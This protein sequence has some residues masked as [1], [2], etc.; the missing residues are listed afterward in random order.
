MY[1]GPWQ[2][3]ALGRALTQQQTR[4][5]GRLP[6]LREEA[7]GAPSDAELSQFVSA[8]KDAAAQLDEA[9][10]KNLLLWSPLFMP[11][12]QT[13][14]QPHGAAPPAAAAA[15]PA[16]AG[17]GR[18]RGGTAG[19][20]AP[21]SDGPRGASSKPPRRKDPAQTKR[22]NVQRQRDDRMDQ[23]RKLY[24]Y[25]DP[26]SCE[27]TL[28][29]DD[30]GEANG[31]QQGFVRATAMPASVR[32]IDCGGDPTATAAALPLSPARRTGSPPS[33]G[34]TPLRR[35]SPARCGAAHLVSLSDEWEDE[36]DDLL[37]WTMALPGTPARR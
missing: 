26:E 10:A 16:R 7:P 18:G 31:P 2:E 19:A 11:T 21:P 8:F 9:G 32:E 4:G 20:A 14:L 13:L 37:E 1:I 3:F 34:A 15:A 23:L 29:P 6:G 30:G 27:T 28:L 24:G 22:A 35:V 17:G 12:V 36:V 25:A 33:R 5:T